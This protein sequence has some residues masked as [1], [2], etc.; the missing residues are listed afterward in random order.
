MKVAAIVFIAAVATAQQF[1]FQSFNNPNYDYN[2]DYYNNNRF[3]GNYFQPQNRFSSNNFFNPFG[4]NQYQDDYYRQN[5]NRIV[6]EQQFQDQTSQQYDTEFGGEFEPLNLPSGASYLLGDI[7]SSFSCA[8]RPYGYYA[9]VDN[10]CRVFHICNPNLFQDGTVQTYQ[11]S[12]MCG[13]RTMFD[14]RTLT[15]V[16]ETK[17][18]PCQD[19][20]SFYWVNENFGLPHEKQ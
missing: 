14:Q 18:S 10:F 16:E 6:Q 2:N 8:D 9:D 15:C 11:Y 3:S 19:A 17:A 5:Q 20:P 1:G 12:M 13:E 4:N 7:S